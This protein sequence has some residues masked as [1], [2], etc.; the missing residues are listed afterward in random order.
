MNK[1]KTLYQKYASTILYGVFGGLTT[2]VNIAVY[3]FAAHPFMIPTM[4]STI[5]AWAAAVTFAY[6]TNRKWV[7]HSEAHTKNEIIKEISSFFSCR[8]AT[9]AVDWFCMW[10]FVDVL[11]LNDIAIKTIANVVVII[12]NYV[13]SKLIIFKHKEN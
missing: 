1:V 5:L 9:G 6:V 13:A 3:W 12:L 10:L 7:F 2:L 8:L 11:L 4:P